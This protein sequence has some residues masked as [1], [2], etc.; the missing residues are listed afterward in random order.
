MIINDNFI[1][2][3]EMILSK[4]E[5]SS[6]IYFTNAEIRSEFFTDELKNYIFEKSLIQIEKE[7]HKDYFYRVHN[8]Y[9]VN[10]NYVS[11]ISLCRK[12]LLKLCNNIWIPVSER[13]KLH[14]LLKVKEYFYCGK[15]S[16]VDQC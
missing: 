7:L 12:P 16:L 14:L 9:I 4:I 13:R 1:I 8:N 15:G 3:K 2:E 6:I 5:L 10:L 11:E